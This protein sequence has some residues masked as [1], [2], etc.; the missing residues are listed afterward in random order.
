[1]MTS[2]VV[3]AVERGTQIG[4]DLRQQDIPGPW[5]VQHWGITLTLPS[6][7]LLCPCSSGAQ[8]QQAPPAPAPGPLEEAR[9][10][11]EP[12]ELESA[13]EADSIT[14]LLRCLASRHQITGIRTL[15]EVGPRAPTALPV[16]TQYVEGHGPSN[17]QFPSSVSLSGVHRC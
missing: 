13:G 7:P 14:Q 10:D 6:M 3:S 16:A 17:A 2:R 12:R 4:S 15:L 9:S 8:S 11:D 5:G 1:M